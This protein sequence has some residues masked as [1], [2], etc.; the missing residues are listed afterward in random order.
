MSAPA[1]SHERIDVA[2]LRAAVERS[3]VSL[4][5]IARR[6]GWLR[7]DNGRGDATRLG[8]ALGRVDHIQQWRCPH[9]GGVARYGRTRAQSID[10]AIALRIA[11]AIH[12]PPYEVDL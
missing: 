3:G 2:P 1:A 6:I 8:R 11:E 10:R 5:E 9:C 12:V 7:S 4:M